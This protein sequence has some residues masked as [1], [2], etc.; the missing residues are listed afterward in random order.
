MLKLEIYYD[1]DEKLYE[2]YTHPEN[3]IDESIAYV[4][5]GK[6]GI[7]LYC[8]GTNFYE[9]E[10]QIDEGGDSHQID[11]A[12]SDIDIVDMESIEDLAYYMV[13]LLN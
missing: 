3:Y 2:V 10:H 12:L 6:R 9:A 7:E 13:S 11:D 8:N 1:T 5:N 4:K